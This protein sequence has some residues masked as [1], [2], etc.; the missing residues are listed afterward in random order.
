MPSVKLF[1]GVSGVATHSSSS[2]PALTPAASASPAQTSK[3]TQPNTCIRL[4][5]SE[6]D[7]TPGR[8]VDIP[9]QALAAAIDRRRVLGPH[10]DRE[11]APRLAGEVR[12]AP[13]IG[14]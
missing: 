14:Q 3:A 7:R 13:V 8:V 12:A 11:A 9:R 2:A 1:S 6:D 10:V 4:P 5:S